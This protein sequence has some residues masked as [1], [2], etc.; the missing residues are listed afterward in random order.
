M[1]NA[2]GLGS[3]PSRLVY[4]PQGGMYA[5]PVNVMEGFRVAP[6]RRSQMKPPAGL[7]SDQEIYELSADTIAPYR[8]SDVQRKAIKEKLNLPEEGDVQGYGGITGGYFSWPA[9]NYDA[10][11]RDQANAWYA[12]FLPTPQGH[13]LV[14]LLNGDWV[15]V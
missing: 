6:E 2:S 15:S 14:Q 11:T 8:L 13:G 3:D 12:S 9:D 1:T 10:T 7:S 5:V 4:D